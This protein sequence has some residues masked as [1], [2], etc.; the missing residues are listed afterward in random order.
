MRE[1]GVGERVGYDGL[2]TSRRVSRI[3]TLGIGYADGY[4]RLAGTARQCGSMASAVAL[5][6]RVSMDSISV[7]VTDCAEV[8]IGD[9][10]ML[11]GPDCRRRTIAQ[12][13]GTVS[14][15]LLARIGTAGHPRIRRLAGVMNINTSTLAG[16]A[17]IEIARPEKKNALTQAMYQ[18]MAEAIAAAARGYVLCA[19]C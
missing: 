9:E 2:W 18:A 4:P 10:A 12:C 1:I 17:T 11:W 3:A 6:G 8:A 5:V 19:H 14:Y 15:E 13:A 16:V 7:D